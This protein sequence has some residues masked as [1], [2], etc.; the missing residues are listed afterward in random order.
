MLLSLCFALYTHNPLLLFQKIKSF[1]HPNHAHKLEILILRRMQLIK[2]VPKITK[3]LL[4][5]T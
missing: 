3:Q 2:A 5:N 4:L 1:A